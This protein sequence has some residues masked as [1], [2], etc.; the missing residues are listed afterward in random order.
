MINMELVISNLTNLILTGDV[1]KEEV[2]ELFEEL[3]VKTLILDNGYMLH[4]R[5]D[6]DYVWVSGGHDEDNSAFELSIGLFNAIT[7]SD[8]KVE[9]DE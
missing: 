9:E 3:H 8:M 1:A 7:K 2:I 5:K 6:A 4:C